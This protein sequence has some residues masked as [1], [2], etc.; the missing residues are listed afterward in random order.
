MFTDQGYG[1]FQSVLSDTVGMAQD[2]SLGAFHLIVEEFT[3]VLHEDSGLL[4]VN[5]SHQT[6]NL[7]IVQMQV[8]HSFHDIGQLTHTGGFDQDAFRS[9]VIDDLLDRLTEITY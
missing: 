4:R 1:L 6:V 2:D 5:N 8:F 9:K 3:E 7:H